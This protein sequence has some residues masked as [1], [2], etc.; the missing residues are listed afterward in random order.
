[1][2]AAPTDPTQPFIC[3]KVVIGE[4]TY[5]P[6][7][8]VFEPVVDCLLITVNGQMWTI[9]LTAWGISKDVVRLIWERTPEKFTELPTKS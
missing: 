6:R 4:I 8:E 5:D 7:E 2:T 9:R 1:M 3:A